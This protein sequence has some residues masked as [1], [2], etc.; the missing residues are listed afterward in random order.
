MHVPR[1]SVVLLGVAILTIVLGVTVAAR[2][3][4]AT[5]QQQ[6]VSW[7]GLVGEP[8]SAV[9]SGQRMIVVL[10][11]PSVAERLAHVRYATEAQERSWASQAAAAQRQVLITLASQ[12]MTVRPDFSYSRVLDGF[13]AP[14]DPRA[15]ALLE[16][17][18]EVAGIYPVRAAFPASVSE[19]LL[20]TR[21]FD[22]TSGHRPDV[23]LPGY[24]GR[25]VTIALLDTGVDLTHPY[26]RGRILP[27]LDL[28]NKGDDATARSNPQD[29][30]QVEH[31][32]TEL[33][34]LL[35][36]AG[37]PGGLHGVAPGATVLQ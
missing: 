16:H 24:D 20:S 7:R 2:G 18:P 37:G 6:A 1:R 17:L 8:R 14:L 23:D 26:L 36:G 13:A 30:S 10:H 35:I 9:P 11:T 28:V 33:A 4:D 19:T 3:R 31:H 29:P 32:G 15:V 34:G 5:A 21:A 27:G 25:G 12:G 22:A